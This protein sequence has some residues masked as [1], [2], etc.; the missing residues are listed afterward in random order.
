M[1][2]VNLI[3]VLV[4]YN[5]AACGSGPARL[6]GLIPQAATDGPSPV[7]WLLNLDLLYLPSSPS[8]RTSIL[9]LATFL[10][11][12]CHRTRST[13]DRT[14]GH[15]H[16]HWFLVTEVMQSVAASSIGRRTTSSP[17]SSQTN[18]SHYLA[19]SQ[20]IANSQAIKTS[21]RVWISSN[22]SSCNERPSS[23]SSSDNLDLQ[24]HPVSH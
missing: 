14:L 19:D 12:S 23:Y 4:S 5:H 21:H 13:I 11:S 7:S 22:S 6:V 20:T 18:S 2:H 24:R 8:C 16:P 17:F 1:S 3:C 9:Q 10:V 15:S